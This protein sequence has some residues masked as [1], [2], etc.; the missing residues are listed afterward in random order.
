MTQCEV[1]QP[2]WHHKD[3]SNFPLLTVSFD[4]PIVQVAVW[5]MDECLKWRGLSDVGGAVCVCGCV[6]GSDMHINTS[7]VPQMSCFH[8]LQREKMT[9][10]KAQFTWTQPGILL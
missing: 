5:P 9:A 2:L 1:A 6:C 3:I 10:L 7:F 8:C 4:K